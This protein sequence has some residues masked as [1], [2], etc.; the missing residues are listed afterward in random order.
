MNESMVERFKENIWKKI[1][2][3]N[4]TFTDIITKFN[5]YISKYIQIID[6]ATKENKATNNPEDAEK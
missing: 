6:K 3:N 5:I 2:Y 1:I 4:T